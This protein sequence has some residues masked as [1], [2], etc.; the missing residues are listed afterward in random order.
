MSDWTLEQIATAMQGA[1]EGAPRQNLEVTG[2][3]IDS[4]TVKPGEVFVAIKGE[5]HDGHRFIPDVLQKEV[6][7]VVAS[8]SATLPVD[9]NG[10]PVVR[11]GDCLNALQKLAGW[12][13]KRHPGLFLGITG[14][15]GKTTT[16]EMLAHLFSR[17]SSLWATAGNLN[18]HIGLPLNLV[19]IPLSCQTAIMEMGMNHAGEIRFL[20]ELARPTS[21]IITGIG[22]AHIG[23]LGSLENIALAKAEM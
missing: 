12:H 6:S 9:R 3:S 10:V 17:V 14:S 16:K 5:N 18:N 23:N 13:R 11:V 7:A 22:P 2:F 15:N 21:G 20:A 8:A 1:V 19:R 4:R